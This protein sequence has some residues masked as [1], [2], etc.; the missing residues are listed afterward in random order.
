MSSSLCAVLVAVHVVLYS[1]P[2]FRFVR[3]ILVFKGSNYVINIFYLWYLTICEHFMSLCEINDSRDTCYEYL[4]LLTKLTLLL[5]LK[6]I[7][8]LIPPQIRAQMDL[9]VKFSET[10]E[11]SILLYLTIGYTA[12]KYQKY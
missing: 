10:K 9:T 6:Q 7:D 8:L 1:L 12:N 4:I 11:L 3:V 5:Q 2:L